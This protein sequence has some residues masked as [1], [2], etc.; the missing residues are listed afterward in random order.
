MERRKFLKS[1]LSACGA[2]AL[3]PNLTNPASQG[4]RPSGE[5]RIQYIRQEIPAFEIP[6]Y[7]GAHYEDRVP[8]TLDLTERAKLAINAVTATDS[9]ADCEVYEGADFD[10]NPPAMFHGFNDWVQICEGMQEALPLLRNATG[11]GLNS[12]VDPFWMRTLLKSIGPDG[13]L[14]VPMKGRPW[15]YLGLPDWEVGVVWRADGSTTHPTDASV[16]QISCGSIPGRTVATMTAYYLRDK[17]PMWKQA[18]E[19]MIQRVGEVA[20]D[21]GDYAYVSGSWEPYAKISR[22]APMPVDV[23]AEETNGRL[24]QGFVQYYKVSGY[25]PALELAG[26]FTKFVRYHAPYFDAQGRFL[27]EKYITQRSGWALGGAFHAHTLELLCMLEYATAANDH[28]TTDFVKASYEWITKK[29]PELFG[30]SSLVGWFPE[31]CVPTHPHPWCEAC[32]FADMVALAVKL[33]AGGTGDYWDDLDRWMR[34][35]VAEAQLTDVDWVYRQTEHSPRKPVRSHETA[36]WVPERNVGAWAGWAHGNEWGRGVSD[37]CTGNSARALYYAWEYM[38]EHQGGELRLNMLANRASQWADVYSYIPY[39]GRVDMKMKQACGSVKVRAPEWI[40]SESPE[41]VCNLN[42]SPRRLN[43]QGRYVDAGAAKAGDLLSI[44]FPIQERTVKERIGPIGY[45][46][47]LR[48]NTVVSI[49]PPGKDGAL[50]QGR[51]KYRKEDVQWRKVDRF[52]AEDEIR[53]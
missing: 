38:L 1:S 51:D 13:L 53:W 12:H 49:D 14:Y 26:K 35:H 25:E 34:N 29:C 31:T 30:A 45:T 23:V 36:Y 15:S 10:R 3:S 41:L 24:I 6:P 39:K 32:G 16:A 28:E 7:R 11:E 50:Y 19:R 22:D 42:G 8:D 18:A 17:N 48:G 21:K 40:R 2:M 44:S 20:I 33:G 43:W 9:E 4:D 37:C 46:L 5:L 52:V 47:V 27:P